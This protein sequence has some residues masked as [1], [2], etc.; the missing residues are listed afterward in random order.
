MAGETCADLCTCINRS[1]LVTKSNPAFVLALACTRTHLS[2]LRDSSL[3]VFAYIHPVYRFTM[4]RP[5]VRKLWGVPGAMFGM[6]PGRVTYVIDKV[7][8]VLPSWHG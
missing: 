2:A 5:Q 7:S 6:V 1:Q 3:N 4:P 8:C